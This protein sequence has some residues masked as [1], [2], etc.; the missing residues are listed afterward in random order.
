[1]EWFF[2]NELSLSIG[3]IKQFF[4]LCTFIMKYDLITYS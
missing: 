2:L 1:M 4:I 3:F